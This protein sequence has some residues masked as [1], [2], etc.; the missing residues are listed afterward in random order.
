MTERLDLLEPVA[1]HPAPTLDLLAQAIDLSDQANVLDS[2][3]LCG[4]TGQPKLLL[5][6]LERCAPPRQLLP[7]TVAIKSDVCTDPTAITFCRR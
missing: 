7:Q 3:L 2:L 4:L 6:G 1:L 5:A